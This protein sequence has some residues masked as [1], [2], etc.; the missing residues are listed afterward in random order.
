[1]LSS[2]PAPS[3]ALRRPA[4]TSSHRPSTFQKRCP[5][6]VTGR[7]GKRCTS[8]RLK[9]CPSKRASMTRPLSA[10]RSTAAT[11]R[12]AIALSLLLYLYPPGYSPSRG[13]SRDVAGRG[14]LH[15]PGEAWG[16]LQDHPASPPHLPIALSLTHFFKGQTRTYPP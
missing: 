8:S 16:P 15:R 10:P 14:C 7:L 3:R 2:F 6:S 4:S 12:V 11:L 5:C 13:G 9:C 1:M